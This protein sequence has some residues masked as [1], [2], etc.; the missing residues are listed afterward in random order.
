MKIT[1]L[2][3][4]N[5]LAHEK[6]DLPNRKVPPKIARE[7]FSRLSIWARIH[8][9]RCRVK[10]FFDPIP[11]DLIDTKYC[12]VHVAED[13]DIADDDIVK[14]ASDYAKSQYPCVVVTNDKDLRERVN[15]LGFKSIDAEFF[16]K[17][18]KTGDE[19]SLPADWLEDGA[20]LTAQ[21]TTFSTSV[22]DKAKIRNEVIRENPEQTNLVNQ[23]IIDNNVL[24]SMERPQIE[25]K[26]TFN[27]DNFSIPSIEKQDKKMMVRINIQQWPKKEGLQF[28]IQSS[29]PKHHHLYEPFLVEEK[30]DYTENLNL[31]FDLFLRLCRGES[32]L[33]KRGGCLMDKVKLILINEYPNPVYYEDLEKAI[34]KNGLMSKLKKS[35]GKWVELV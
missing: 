11:L 35:D 3:D 16:A 7:L 13:D 22:Q 33:V 4:G 29:C 15:E 2:I 23:Q 9:D 5:N 1:V 30:L 10:L 28:L 32:D 19:F 6:Y 14:I 31:V 21:R 25:E 20:F 18:S 17:K 26:P 8:Q 34:N 12:R 27:I 24:L